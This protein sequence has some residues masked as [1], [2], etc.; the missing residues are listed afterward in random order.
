MDIRGHKI[1]I[2]GAVR[3]GVSAA[4]LATAEG[5]IAFVS[6]N[7]STEDVI[8]NVKVLTGLGIN[9]ETGGHTSKVFD[10]DYIVTS[11]GVPSNAPVLIEA[12]EKG[13]K[14][15][16]EIEFASWFCKGDII[17]ITG[18]NGKTTTT[19]LC[20][21]VLNSNGVKCHLAGNIGVPFSEVVQNVKENEFVALELSSFQLDFID[22][23][24]PKFSII[25]NITQDHLDRYENRFDLYIKSK[26][27]IISNQNH[28]D[29]FIFN[30]EDYNILVG[31][32]SENIKLFPFSLEK[33]LSNGCFC[34]EEWIV[35]AKNRDLSEICKLNEL[36]LKGEH[37]IQNSM[38]VINVAM[39]LGISPE[40]IKKSLSTFKGVEHR[41]EFVRQFNGIN[42]IN[43]SKATNVD[44]VWYALRSFDN[45]IYLIL[46]GKDKGNDYSKIRDEIKKRVKKIYAIGS[47][48]QKIYEYFKN[49]TEVE[50]VDTFDEVI[51]KGIKEA[52]EGN[53]LL[54]SPACASFDMFKN[55]EDRGYQ[56]K[57]IVNELL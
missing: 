3:S 24:R 1:S 29:V 46:G 28:D 27:K 57:K 35:F 18:T 32:A 12:L 43:D 20:A 36:S 4:K 23:F 25:L 38:A 44:S 51:N 45:P 41:L 30:G 16:S 13:L 9:T 14:V 11:P 33:I 31:Y 7:S 39:N 26:M 54:L 34:D 48:S 47:S 22:T 6:D 17:A 52:K 50:I 10:C 21:Y 42:I 56:F 5:A 49:I 55:Y 8:E 2:L 37:N 19:T 53:V 40:G 15:Y